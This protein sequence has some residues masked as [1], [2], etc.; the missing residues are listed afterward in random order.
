MI[1]GAHKTAP[2]QLLEYQM[3]LRGRH[4]CHYLPI[5]MNREVALFSS[6]HR[7]PM[8]AKNSFTHSYTH[9]LPMHAF[10]ACGYSY[11]SI[12]TLYSYLTAK[13]RHRILVS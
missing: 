1:S 13:D 7:N 5:H 3:W 4:H 9:T 2:I 6:A 8:A 11:N 10:A 12:Y